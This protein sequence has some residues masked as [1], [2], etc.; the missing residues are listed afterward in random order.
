MKHLLLSLCFPNPAFCY[1]LQRTA[2]SMFHF[3][4]ECRSCLHFLNPS[5]PL[6]QFFLSLFIC[7]L[8]SIMFFFVSIIFAHFLAS[9]VSVHFSNVYNTCLTDGF[10]WL[11]VFLLQSSFHCSLIQSARPSP[12]CA[13]RHHFIVNSAS[14]NIPAIDPSSVSFSPTTA[15]FCTLSQ[16]CNR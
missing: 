2:I 10:T 13:H 11:P 4:H 16:I 3:F 5:K 12:R 6:F 15:F 14:R 8:W 9:P 1:H 7:L